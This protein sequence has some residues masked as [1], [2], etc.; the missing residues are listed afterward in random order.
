[1]PKS[2]LSPNKPVFSKGGRIGKAKEAKK[3][4]R[5]AKEQTEEQ[6]VTGWE[7]ATLTVKFF[8]KVKRRR[9]SLNFMA[10]LKSAIDGVVD[11]K[12][13]PDDDST[14]LT[15]YPPRFYVDT[16][17]EDRVEMTFTRVK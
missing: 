5:L 8:H 9:D 14:V 15:P 1:M 11:A 3:Y 7:E 10:M 16:E 4:R 2:I 6:Q 12:L 17:C 13:I